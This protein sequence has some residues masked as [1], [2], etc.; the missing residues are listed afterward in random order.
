M[1][2]S[3]V[4][5]ASLSFIACTKINKPTPPM[6]ETYTTGVFVSN[7]GV[8]GSGES[9]LSHISYNPQGVTPTA[10]A[11]KNGYTLG[12]IFQS[13]TEHNG[14]LYMVINNSSAIEVADAR[15]LKSKGQIT[16]I[17]SP[18]YMVTDGNLGFV[19][20]WADDAVKV[21]DLISN[22]V[23]SSIPV[24][25]DPEGM[26]VHN[27]MLY[28]ANS[29]GSIYPPAPDSTMSVIEIATLTEKQKV[30]LDLGPHS[31]QLDANGMIWVVCSGLSDF[32]DPSRDS[33][34]SLVKVNPTT[35]A[36][37][38]FIISDLSVHPARLTT[39]G[40]MDKMFFTGNLYGGSM[41]AMD[42]TAS[43]APTAPMI[44]ENFYGLGVH[45]TTSEIYR[46]YSPAFDQNGFV[47]RYDQIGTLIDSTS[48]G[49]GPNSF[50]FID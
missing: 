41:Y 20:D 45:P 47:Y 9:T 27:G 37:D 46:G 13:M 18:R 24:G 38:N 21:V 19:S 35:F 4:A 39:N 44:N 23:T 29:G 7:E 11:N 17:T 28:V 3:I 2:K 10:F 1:R 12:D 33:E 26:F 32:S 48:V 5:L 40:A 15:T 16:G 49:I 34:G 43:M 50:L 6:D 36:T 25:V 14:N 22:T 31:I 8:F 42:I 30:V